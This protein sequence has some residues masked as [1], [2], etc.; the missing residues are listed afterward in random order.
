MKKYILLFIC[1]LITPCLVN[2]Q[3]TVNLKGKVVDESKKPV[4][5]AMVFLDYVNTGKTTNSKGIFKL[6][7]SKRA[8]L[9]T[10]FSKR[11]GMISHEYGRERRL[12]FIFPENAEL[13]P[14][15]DLPGLG[16]V[17]EAPKKNKRN[18]FSDYSTIWEILDDRYQQVRIKDGHIIIGRGG[19]S[20]F[21][22]SQDPLILLEG[23]PIP[24]SGLDNIATTEIESIN[25]IHKGSESAAYGFR[26]VN[27]V[28]EI[29]LKDGE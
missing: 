10:I 4:V 25:I 29:K 12:D 14:E 17:L 13:I 22:A 5:G 7:A 1:V 18:W 15:S 21:A 24:V 2:A 28:I 19:P 16:F 27:G 11:H 6:K 9:I 3:K 8:K 20:V 23:Q 26:G